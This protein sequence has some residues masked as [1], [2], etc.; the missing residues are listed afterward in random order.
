MLRRRKAFSKDNRG[1][2]GSSKVELVSIRA[3]RCWLLRKQ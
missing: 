1:V 3:S 2:E